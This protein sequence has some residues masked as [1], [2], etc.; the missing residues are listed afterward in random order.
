VVEG[1]LGA[2]AVTVGRLTVRM[3]DEGQVTTRVAAT[4]SAQFGVVTRA[5]LSQLGLTRSAV[6]HLVR[7]GRLHRISNRVCVIAG[8]P[9]TW[10]RS[11]YVA[12]ADTGGRGAISHWAAAAHWRLPGFRRSGLHVVVPRGLVDPR[13]IRTATLH[14]TR[15]LPAHHIVEHEGIRT[16]SPVRTVFDLSDVVPLGRLARVLDDAWGMRLLR[17]DGLFD[18][19]EELKGR[20]RGRVAWMRLLIEERGRGY[21]APES[22]LERCFRRLL[23]ADGQAPMEYQV[24]LGGR[25]WVARVDAVDRAA[26]LVVQIDSPRHHS[27]LSDRR[28]DGRQDAA[29]RSLGWTVLRF[30]DRDLRHR[31]EWVVSVVRLARKLRT[32]SARSA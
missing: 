7:T 26:R 14:T 28:H 13:T 1:A 30:S 20:G 24:D 10:H 21:A 18:T 25:S 11:A 31:P 2:V 32:P 8:S 22:G 9:P 6:A 3:N 27:S 12:V 5:Q 23:L 17:A 15:A 16:T 4:A 29:L 19:L